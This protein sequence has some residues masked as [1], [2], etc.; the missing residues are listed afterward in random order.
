MSSRCGQPVVPSSTQI[1]SFHL[2]ASAAPQQQWR[3]KQRK[4][5]CP[6]RPSLSRK[7]TTTT[8]TAGSGEALNRRRT[9]SDN[10]SKLQELKLAFGLLSK[11]I[12]GLDGEEGDQCLPCPPT[13]ESSA[14]VT[15]GK[16]RR[17]ETPKPLAPAVKNMHIAP[18]AVATQE[19]PQQS[20]GGL[21]AAANFP[22]KK[23]ATSH[24]GVQ[25]RSHETADGLKRMRGDQ[26]NKAVADGLDR[27]RASSHAEGRKAAEATAKQAKQSLKQLDLEL[28]KE[29]RARTAAESA[30]HQ[31]QLRATESDLEREKLER[32]LASFGGRSLE[33]ITAASQLLER[34]L[35]EAETALVDSQQLT[36]AKAAEGLEALEQAA[37]LAE[38]LETE[39]V[40]RAAAEEARRSVTQQLRCC[41]RGRANAEQQARA[42]TAALKKSEA[43]RESLAQR[44]EVLRTANKRLDKRVAAVALQSSVGTR[45]RSNAGGGGGATDDSV[46]RLAA[47]R[48]RLK[49]L[50]TSGTA[51]SSINTGKG[52]GQSHAGE[53]RAAVERA[54]GTVVAE[55]Q[56][57]HKLRNAEMQGE[58]FQAA[59]KASATGMKI[60]LRQKAELEEM[61][62]VLVKQLAG[63]MPAE[64]REQVGR[65]ID[66]E[67]VTRSP[68][69][70]VVGT[71]GESTHEDLGKDKTTAIL[72]PRIVGSPIE[73]ERQHHA[74]ATQ[75]SSAVSHP[76]VDRSSG[77]PAGDGATGETATAATPTPLRPSD[78]NPEMER[79][80]NTIP[81][82]LVVEDTTAIM[83]QPT[84]PCNR[85][86]QERGQ[87]ITIPPSPSSWVVPQQL[88]PAAVRSYSVDACRSGATRTTS[89]RR[90][91]GCPSRPRSASASAKTTSPSPCTT[92]PTRVRCEPQQQRHHHQQVDEMVVARNNDACCCS[93]S[94]A[95][96]NQLLLESKKLRDEVLSA[97]RNGPLDCEETRRKA[98]S[99]GNGSGN[100]SGDV[101]VGVGVTGGGDAGGR[102]GGRGVGGDGDDG[103]G[104]SQL[105]KV[106]GGT[107]VA[108][109]PIEVLLRLCDRGARKAWRK[110]EVGVADRAVGG[111]KPI[112]GGDA[113]NQDLDREGMADESSDRQNFTES[114]VEGSKMTLDDV[115]THLTSPLPPGITRALAQQVQGAV[116]RGDERTFLN[117]VGRCGSTAREGIA[118]LLDIDF[119][120]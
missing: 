54:V 92:T 29:R 120:E 20:H 7:A 48:V 106:G 3:P 104:G 6:N 115:A 23:A 13:T 46:A 57:R 16:M 108:S 43:R 41:L 21:A 27:V 111:E 76:A 117:I 1:G 91:D 14:A 25:Q 53:E 107:A 39:R 56:W 15:E 94:A 34:R 22:A 95:P 40:A 99:G 72:V 100:S 101:G 28:E 17:N 12:Q 74:S 84:E 96:F 81:D 51:V 78:N 90:H 71:D 35:R 26:R 79:N 70:L 2:E 77:L 49:V 42:A 109:V 59:A 18:S 11:E 50:S 118:K 64:E 58:V 114:L 38:Q 93:S 8:A 44:L 119:P 19:A 75:C 88:R 112:A 116:A 86:R 69:P 52:R 32:V 105:E 80:D 33:E 85:S 110:R 97:V 24:P 61:N 30:L 82:H 73:S 9:N 63:D 10:A 36:A 87:K 89:P 4:I 37:S 55:K 68:A 47:A 102:S 98:C 83:Q 5:P 45:A 66:D 31:L 65:M 62:R 60:A 113:A 103:Y 67:D